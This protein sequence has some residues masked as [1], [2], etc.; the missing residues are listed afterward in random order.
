M[1]KPLLEL[2]GVTHR[3]GPRVA[4]NDVSLEIHAGEILALVGK[5]GAGKTTLIRLVT[6]LLPLAEGVIERHNSSIGY[7]PQHIIIWP[8]LTVGEQLEFMCDMQE[9][10]RAHAERAAKAVGLLDRW[11]TLGEALSGGMQRRL[12]IALATLHDPGVV[13]LDE[14]NAGLDPGHRLNLREHLRNLAAN[15]TGVVVSSHDLAEVEKVADRVAVL[16]EGKLVALGTPAELA[17]DGPLEARF[18]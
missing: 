1:T 12:S 8:D 4:L 5:N 7:V 3:Y 17:A 10:E 9:V 14:P 11:A 2:R 18:T 6:E 13:V 15:G 16:D